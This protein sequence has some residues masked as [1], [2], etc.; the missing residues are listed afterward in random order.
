MQESQNKSVS[1]L[2]SASQLHMI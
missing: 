1:S 2:T